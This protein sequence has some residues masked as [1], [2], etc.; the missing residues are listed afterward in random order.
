MTTPRRL[1]MPEID[2]LRGIAALIVVLYHYTTRYDSLYG[3][4][5]SPFLSVPWGHYGVNIFFMISGFVIFMSLNATK[6]SADFVVSRLTRLFPIYWAAIIFTTIFVGL[7]GLPNR[8]IP[9]LSTMGNLGMVHNLFG[10][11][12]VD[13]VYWTLEVELLFYCWA[14]IAFST[15]SLSKTHL[16]FALFFLARLVSFWMERYFQA[17]L[18]ILLSRLLILKYIPW[19][20]AGIMIFRLVTGSATRLR[21]I[22]LLCSAIVLMVIVEGYRLGA[23]M[24]TTS[25]VLYGAAAGKLSLNHRSLVWLGAISYPLYLVHQNV[26]YAL[27]LK[28]ET[29]GVNPNIA[30]TTAIFASFS[31]AYFLTIYVDRPTMGWLRQQYKMRRQLSEERRARVGGAIGQSDVENSLGIP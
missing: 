22:V 27:I 15:G 31:V 26:G 29:V 13:G 23:I 16:L 17:E 5:S 7:I 19:F 18:P 24:A 11:P 3:H 14:L 20:G 25:I 10:I 2:A 8:E 4:T 28:L 1:R 12:H 30:V 21:D 9:L 6:S